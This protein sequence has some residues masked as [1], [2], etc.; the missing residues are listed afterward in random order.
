MTF[1][2]L[3]QARENFAAA[4][5]T[6]HSS[7]VRSA[8]T[9]LGIVIGVSSVISMAAIIQGLNKFVQ[10]RVESLG[11]RTYFLTR[12]PPGT[13]PAHMP[14]KIR[15]RRYIG[16]DY[17]EFIRAAAPDVENINTVG[18]RGFFFGDSNR[19]T[20]GDHTVEKVIVRGAEPEYT[21]ALPLFNIEHGRF[22]SAFDQEHSRPVVVLG[23]AIAESLFPDS[24]PLGKT[25]RLNG[26]VYEVIGI[27]THDQ[28]LFLGPG[29]DIFAII[30]LS[31]FKK[32]YPEAKELIMLFTVPRDVNVETAQGEVIQAMRRIRKIP[33]DKEN[34]FELS[35]PDFL[36]NLWNQLTGA[37]V[38]LTSVI[39]SIGLLV[40]G[41]GVMNIMLI[42]VTERT[43]EIG[44][45]K[46]IGARKADVRL[47]F[48]FEAVVLT[49]IGGTIGILIGAGVSTA[50]RALAP[51]IPATLSYWWVSIGFAM[52]VGVGLFFGYYPANLAANLDPI[53]CLRYE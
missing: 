21:T 47:Q 28:G 53:T 48:L 43:Q 11:S 3:A 32:Q 25:V 36:S 50:V 33:A 41:V 37:L 12:F 15:I 19:I 9:V 26:S 38:I 42:S 17:A 46:A 52:S 18:T 6:L 35:S 51:S 44:V 10:D 24:D 29:V 22:I 8:L 7:K 40:G 23:A 16:Y 30:P 31:N 14:D 49:L 27:F 1:M 45:R 39:S 20:S 4:M 5:Q 13:D 2:T 34:D